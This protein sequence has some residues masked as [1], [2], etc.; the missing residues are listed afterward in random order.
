MQQVRVPTGDPDT[1]SWHSLIELI[2]EEI[3]AGAPHDP[4]V[5]VAL[6]AARIESKGYGPYLPAMFADPD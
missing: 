4:K 5:L 3:A 2:A 6:I 1:E